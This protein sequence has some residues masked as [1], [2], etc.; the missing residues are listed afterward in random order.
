[1]TKRCSAATSAPAPSS[2]SGGGG[3]G[4]P[5]SAGS[6]LASGKGLRPSSGAIDGR[7]ARA[8][9]SEE[10]KNGGRT[11]SPSLLRR[12]REGKAGR[13]L[14]L[15]PPPLHRLRTRTGKK[16]TPTSW[17]FFNAPAGHPLQV[18]RPSACSNWPSSSRHAALL[19]HNHIIQRESSHVR[20]PC[21][22]LGGKGR[23]M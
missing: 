3:C 1:M 9:N 2:P 23:V 6:G 19:A 16:K 21:T 20:L 12:A 22:R 10:S 11:P 15:P 7:A 18:S 17:L 4:S 13:Q 8:A 5:P 14:S